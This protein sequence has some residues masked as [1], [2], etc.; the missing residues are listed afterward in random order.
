MVS[1]ARRR[2][3]ALVLVA[4]L[5]AGAAS[6]GDSDSDEPEASPTATAA[7]TWASDLCSS[8]GTWTTTVDEARDQLSKPRELSV[9]EVEA[10]FDQVAAASSALVTELRGLGAPES[11]AG[12]EAEDRLTALA[13]ELE[14]QR[15]VVEGAVAEQPATMQARL[16]KVSTVTG[17]A[18]AMSAEAK[19]AVDDLKALDGAAE[20]QDAF[21]SSDSC[22]ELGS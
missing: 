3:T 5:A 21:A 20:L 10:S 18:A 7:E 19:S 15:E 9:D 13:D 14:A 17:A 11:D 16:E 4:A 22:Q 1:T 6:C 8:I 2:L 12:D